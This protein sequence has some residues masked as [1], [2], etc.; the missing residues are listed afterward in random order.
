[1][2]SEGIETRRI[3]LAREV[4]DR[5]GGRKEREREDQGVKQRMGGE[6]SWQRGKPEKA[7]RWG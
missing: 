5:V 7:K 3:S 2:R 6:V 4:E 1:M